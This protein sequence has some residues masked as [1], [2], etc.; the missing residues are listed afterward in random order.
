MRI[1][2]R[3]TAILCGLL[4]AS[5]VQAH[6]GTATFHAFRLDVAAGEN[7]DNASV[8]NWDLDGWIGGD[9][10]KL[11][12]KSEGEVVDHVTE[13][14]ETWAMYSYNIATFWDLQAGVRYDSQPEST[15]YFVA[16]FTGLAPYYFETEAHFFASEDGDIGFRL[17][18]ENDFLLTQKLI[19]Q[20]YL[21]LNAYAQDVKELG[22]G[23][24]LS[25]ASLG[26]QLRYEVTRKIAPYVEVSYGRLFGDT[27]DYAQ[28][29][30]EDRNDSSVTA[31][32]R[33]M[34]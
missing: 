18:E 4:L 11:W 12:L 16:G 25:D 15:G 7:R 5:A 24:G 2:V 32:I 3:L 6:D 13:H 33:L 20:P 1:D 30:G 14:S 22:V 27:A 21:E 9:D 29:R 8:A 28:S 17:R 31:G 34:F 19:V 26:L 10:H 23:S